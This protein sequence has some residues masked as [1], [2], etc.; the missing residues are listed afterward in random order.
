MVPGETKTKNDQTSK[1]V[2]KSNKGIRIGTLNCFV[3]GFGVSPNCAKH[4]GETVVRLHDRRNGLLQDGDNSPSC[5]QP[6]EDAGPGHH[7]IRR[8]NSWSVG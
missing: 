7:H 6:K 3:I 1:K 4:V 2:K 8:V 5:R